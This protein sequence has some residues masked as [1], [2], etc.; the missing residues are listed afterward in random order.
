[1]KVSWRHKIN[2]WKLQARAQ[3]ECGPKTRMSR[4]A[5]SGQWVCYSSMQMATF[6][7][8]KCVSKSVCLCTG[9]TVIGQAQHS[10]MNSVKYITQTF[11]IHKLLTV[12]QSAPKYTSWHR[13]FPRTKLPSSL[14][15][16]V[17]FCFRMLMVFVVC[18]HSVPSVCLSSVWTN[19]FTYIKKRNTIYCLQWIIWNS[20][21]M[22]VRSVFRTTFFE[23][24]LN[25]N[26]CFHP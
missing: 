25:K 8:D 18:T 21:L 6:R 13:Q 2:P 7:A 15:S 14:L 19:V 20:L 4:G 11:H 23:S 5:V 1:M 24:K 12:T 22:K 9:R 3:E 10:A 17:A 16:V 26:I